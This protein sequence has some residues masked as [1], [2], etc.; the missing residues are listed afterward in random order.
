[1]GFRAERRRGMAGE[2]EHCTHHLRLAAQAVGI[3]HAIVV[4]EMRSANRAAG[5]Q[6][7][8]G[9]GDLDLAAAAAQRMDA[10]GERR[11]G[12]FASGAR[13]PEVPTEPWLG[14]TGMRS[15]A[16]MASSR[17]RVS[18]RTPEA[19]WPRLASLS[20]IITRAFDAG[21]GS[22]TPAACESTMLRWSV[23]RSAGP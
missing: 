5:H 8:Q 23:A 4:H 15:R 9:G 16:S 7:A 20:A 12:A 6:G 18:G 22:P 1:V 3:L 10:R 17:A 2:V 19:P 21:A 13:S 14:I 11:G